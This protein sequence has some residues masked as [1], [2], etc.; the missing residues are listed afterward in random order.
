M[1]TVHCIEDAPSVAAVAVVQGVSEDL[2]EHLLAAAAA[3]AAEE[4]KKKV[5]SALI[6]FSDEKQNNRTFAMSGPG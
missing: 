4:K 1:A 5:R 3:A 2:D 6:E